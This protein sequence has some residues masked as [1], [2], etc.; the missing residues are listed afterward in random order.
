MRRGAFLRSLLAVPAA[1]VGL[2]AIG[3][4]PD[5]IRSRAVHVPHFGLSTMERE[6]LFQRARDNLWQD[7]FDRLAADAK[8]WL[9]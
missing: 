6:N 4:K 9:P 1:F 3:L 2:G 5:V 7:M 8:V